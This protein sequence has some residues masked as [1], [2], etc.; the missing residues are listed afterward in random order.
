M[1]II[2]AMHMSDALVSAKTGVAMLLLSLGLLLFATKAASARFD[3]LDIPL[4][5]IMGAFVFAAQM[6]NFSIP[7]TGSS[8]HISGGILL[9]AVLGAYPAFVALAGVLVIQALFFADGGILALGCNIFN[10]AFFTC[11]VGYP[12]IFLPIIKRFKSAGGIFAA[13]VAACVVSLQLGAFCVVLETLCSGVTELDFKTFLAFMQPI[14]LAIGIVEGVVTAFV[15]VLLRDAKPE[16]FENI[17]RGGFIPTRKTAA[18]L[19]LFAA[20][21]VG[22]G[23]A[24]LAS[25]KPDGLEWSIAKTADTEQLSAPA[26]PAHALG[27]AVAEKTAIFPDYELGGG[28]AFSDTAGSSVFGGAMV[29]AA[30]FV[31]AAAVKFARRRAN[32]K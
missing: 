23:L 9:A 30:L 2:F 20:L 4:M 22:C 11:F 28:D 25:E 12:L 13:S 18:L 17:E 14:H 10:M 19:V 32:A 8:G 1:E 6:V 31:F 29:A 21:V 7:M 26:T 15:L 27:S 16:I 24:Q 5:R 3:S